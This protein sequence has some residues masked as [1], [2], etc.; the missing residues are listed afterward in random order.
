M[1]YM[2]LVVLALV[3]TLGLGFLPEAQA[4]YSCRSRTYYSYPSYSYS[5]PSYSYSYT[6]TY[7]YY[8]PKTYK[9]EI[10]IKEVVIPSFLQIPLYGAY[11]TPPVQVPSVQNGTAPYTPNPAPAASPATPG[12]TPPN[13]AAS[14]AMPGKAP[15]SEVNARVDALE[16]KLNLIL[17]ALETKGVPPSTTPVPSKSPAT[18]PPPPVKDK[19]PTGVGDSSVDKVEAA[20]LAGVKLSCAQCHD[21]TNAAKLGSKG[22]ALGGGFVMVKDGKFDHASLDAK[23]WVK[24]LGKLNIKQMPPETDQ[25]GKPVRDLTEQEYGNLSVLALK[26]SGT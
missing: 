4:D 26:K 7:S 22:K 3:G 8:E 9:E 14:P 12:Y 25:D 2:P 19:E 18:P 5:Y 11:Y 17:K 16:G 15:C 6:P 24:I 23:A 21:A 13:P 10:R 1:R 20:A